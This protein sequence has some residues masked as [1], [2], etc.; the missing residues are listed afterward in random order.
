M[1]RGRG[2]LVLAALLAGAACASARG[3]P[4]NPTEGTLRQIPLGLGMVLPAGPQ[5]LTLPVDQ[6]YRFVSPASIVRGVTTEDLTSVGQ[7]GDLRAAVG[8][9][10]HS[11]GWRESADSAEFDIAIFIGRRTEMRPEVREERIVSTT[12][13]Q[14][15]RCEQSRTGSSPRCTTERDPTVR[16][17]NVMV[18]HTVSRVY[19][20]V[21][22]RDDGA[23]RYWSHAVTDL[24]AVKGAVARD[25]LRTLLTPEG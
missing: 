9:V 15:P 5:I 16:R 25:L 24:E 4:P 3:A 14:L 17:V 10:L 21:R 18:P 8:V 13:N 22:R 12:A 20:V 1:I 23:V 19:H 2:A 6:R 11:R 7:V